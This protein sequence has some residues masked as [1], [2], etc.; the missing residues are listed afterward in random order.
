MDFE[1]QIPQ[2]VENMQLPAPEL[3][4]Y[5]EDLDHRCIWVV[6]EIGSEL[7][8]LT[9]KIMK[10]N[11]EDRLVPVEERIPIRIY[12]FSPGGDLDVTLATLGVI[13]MSKTPV[14]TVNIGMAYSAAGLLLMAGHRR[15]ALPYSQALIHSGS[16]V[17]GGSYEQTT[18]QMKNYQ[19]MVSYM[20]EFILQHTRIEPKLL[21]KNSAKDWYILTDDMLS[22]GLV[23]SIVESLDDIMV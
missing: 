15:F 11:A 19:Q 12:I 5:Y 4:Q 13:G 21:K 3:V 17:I 20:R 1:V 23:D 9:S 7:L 18:E 14:W 10:W 8:D 6:G 2:S 22:L 16:S